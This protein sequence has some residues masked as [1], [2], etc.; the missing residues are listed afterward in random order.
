MTWPRSPASRCSPKPRCLRRGLGSAPPQPSS[1]DPT[2][3]MM[4]GMEADE[5]AR[6]RKMDALTAQ[7]AAEVK[8]E[9]WRAPPAIE[10][11][12]PVV[13]P[14]AAPKSAYAMDF[15]YIPKAAKLGRGPIHG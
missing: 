11:A 15:G 3:M 6:Q 7:Q 5:Q 9:G 4:E 14:A 13:T 2:M 8:A 1:F 10:A 12:P